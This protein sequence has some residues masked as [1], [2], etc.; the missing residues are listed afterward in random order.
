VVLEEEVDWEPWEV[1]LEDYGIE[2]DPP[3]GSSFE[4]DPFHPESLAAKQNT[5]QVFNDALAIQMPIKWQELPAPRK[6]RYFWG[7]EQF[8]VD[9]VKWSADGKLLAFEGSG[10]DM[11]FEERDHFTEQLK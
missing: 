4:D 3:G 10:W 9:I 2:E 11:D 8:P 7:D 1:N 5:Y 6:P